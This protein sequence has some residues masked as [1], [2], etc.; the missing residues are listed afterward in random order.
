MLAGSLRNHNKALLKAVILGDNAMVETALRAGA[1]LQAVNAFGENALHLAAKNHHFSITEQL[2]LYGIDIGTASKEGQTPLHYA[3]MYN[4]LPITQL[5]LMYNPDVNASDKHLMTPLHFAAKN[6]DLSVV[7]ALLNAGA[8]LE[9]KDKRG[10]TPLNYS[11]GYG[12]AKVEY[13]LDAQLPSLIEKYT[14]IY[15]K[16]LDEDNYLGWLPEEMLFETLAFNEKFR[17]I[18]SFLY[19]QSWKHYKKI[20]ETKEKEEKENLKVL[21][22]S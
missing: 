14:P 16:W 10:W 6:A 11:I 4:D 3:A 21:I 2:L 1:N 19:R 22:N 18:Y 17:P 9:I 20:E 5:L 15:G 13:F 8:N 12:D 7:Q